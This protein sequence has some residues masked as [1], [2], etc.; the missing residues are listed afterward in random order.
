MSAVLQE[1]ITLLV[2]GIEQMATGIGQGLSAL[3]NS[4]FLET[5]SG[6]TTPQLSTF[7]GLIVVFAGIALAIGLS[8]F[9]VNW[10]TSL[11]N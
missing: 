4:I 5:P 7:G 1:I 3:A 8:R 6:S 10:V 2:G 11:G 9:V